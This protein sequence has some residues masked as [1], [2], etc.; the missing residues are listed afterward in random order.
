LRNAKPQDTRY[1]IQVGGNTYLEI[2]PTG[3]KVWRMRYLKPEDKKPAIYTIGVY[4]EISLVSARELA[5]KAKQLVTD[6]VS[7]AEHRKTEQADSKIKRDIDNVSFEAVTRQWHGE[8]LSAGKWKGNH[9]AKIIKS[10]EN[11]VFPMIGQY[12]IAKIDAP[13]LLE[14]MR[15]VI[16]RGAIETSKKL[17]QRIGAVFRF[18]IVRK[19]IAFNPSEHIKD[20]LPV[21][22]VSHNPHLTPEQ[23]PAFIG[24]IENS[25]AG[26]RVKLAILITMHNLTRTSETRFAQWSEFD[27]DNQIWNIPAERMKM[28][29]PHSIPLSSQTMLMLDRLKAIGGGRYL[30]TTTSERKPMSENAMLNVLYKAGYKGVITVHGLRGTGSTILNEH[31][32]RFDVIES[33]LA[34]VD[35][36]KIR[37]A[38]NH[39]EY[40]EER[41]A[42]MQH[43][44]NYL[45]S[46]RVSAD[47][48]PINTN[49]T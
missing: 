16:Q 37:S 7:P 17:N 20:E 15:P 47:V 4:P 36:N 40:F 45:D 35:P 6:G 8:R 28:G 46:L 32:F 9:A 49:N 1:R 34:H 23:I 19:L 5:Q 2:M 30:F 18:A 38:Y 43:Y 26:E 31:K 25:Q 27:L 11:D 10:F 14:V 13:L 12:P 33:A 29:K 48:V 21:A 3:K 24:A 41:R 39:A 44:S 42:M 22:E